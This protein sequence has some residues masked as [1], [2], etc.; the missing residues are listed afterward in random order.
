MLRVNTGFGGSLPAADIGTGFV[1]LA[2][3]C[4]EIYASCVSLLPG[5]CHPE[6]L[7]PLRLC[8]LHHFVLSLDSR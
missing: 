6:S 1:Y 8:S 2:V 5:S 7:I 3:R 4:H